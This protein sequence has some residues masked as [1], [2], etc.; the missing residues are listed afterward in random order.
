MVSSEWLCPVKNILV[1]A[2]ENFEF[3][4]ILR[5]SRTVE[6]AD[7][8]IRF[9]R[10]AELNGMRLLLAAH[11]PGSKLAGIA[12]DAVHSRAAVDAI[13]STGLCGG[14]EPELC[15]GD[16]VVAT[17]VNGSTT[18]RPFTSLPHRTGKVL[19]LD[20]VAVT[21]VEKARLHETGASVVEM[22]AQALAERA[23]LWQVPFYCVRSVSDSAAEE[24]LLDLN[25]VR[26]TEG[27]FR[28]GL[29]VLKTVIR[30]FTLVPEL[31]RLKR[32]S[33]RAADS[34][35]EFVANCCF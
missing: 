6:K 33:E 35:G 3:A 23:K 14:L 31:L 15:V 29:I 2:A 27:R 34:L 9:S 22:E 1:V 17:E 26:D 13:V 4:G 24:F 30:P 12:A 10:V 28:R 8:G 32:N 16:I 7:W 20:R 5:R 21:S 11:G 25:A 18:Q 19:S